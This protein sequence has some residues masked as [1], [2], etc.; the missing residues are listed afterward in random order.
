MCFSL[1][2]FVPNTPFLYPLKKSAN[3]KIFWCFQ[4]V[5]EGH[6]GG[7]GLICFS[8]HI[9]S[10]RCRKPLNIIL[11]ILGYTWDWFYMYVCDCI[12]WIPMNWH[13]LLVV[14]L[15][16]LMSRKFSECLWSSNSTAYFIAGSCLFSISKILSAWDCFWGNFLIQGFHCCITLYFQ[17]IKFR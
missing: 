14:S 15:V 16:K 7:N 4:G 13:F 2:P 17:Q 10:A 12:L 5:G 11:V 6:I 1:N 9:A 3:R 8:E